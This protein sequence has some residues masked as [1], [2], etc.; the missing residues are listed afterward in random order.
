MVQSPRT[1]EWPA[2]PEAALQAAPQA[3]VLE[4]AEI[5]GRIA[6]LSLTH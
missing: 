1:A 6:E 3:L 4:L 2:M 5:A